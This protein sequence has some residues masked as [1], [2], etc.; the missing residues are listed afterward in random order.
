MMK[1]EFGGLLIVDV[2]LL[3]LKNPRLRR[4]DQFPCEELLIL[5]GT[6]DHGW[7]LSRLQ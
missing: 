5:T 1:M 2:D 4:S 3:E 7:D 6:L